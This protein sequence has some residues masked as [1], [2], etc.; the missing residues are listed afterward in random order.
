MTRLLYYSYHQAIRIMD[1]CLS[2]LV[3]SEVLFLHTLY[4]VV[5]GT[6]CWPLLATQNS[7]T[8]HLSNVH[9][10]LAIQATPMIVIILFHD[11]FRIIYP[12]EATEKKARVRN[13][14]QL[15]LDSHNCLA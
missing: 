10:S 2:L 5:L 6:C 12:A 4:T 13:P 11:S 14:S 15:V 8:T 3:Y 9:K 7:K 1:S